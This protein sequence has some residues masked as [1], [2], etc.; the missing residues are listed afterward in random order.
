MDCEFAVAGHDVDEAV[1]FC[2]VFV[3][4]F[5]GCVHVEGDAFAVCEA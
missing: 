1:F 5:L 3:V 4:L 2:P